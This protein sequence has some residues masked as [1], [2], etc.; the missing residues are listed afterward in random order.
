MLSVKDHEI[1]SLISMS[2]AINCIEKGFS[3]F[4][5]GLFTMPQRST[6]EVEGGTVLSLSLIH[7]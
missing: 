1:R 4:Y 5:D 7:I 2:D 6:M 3:D